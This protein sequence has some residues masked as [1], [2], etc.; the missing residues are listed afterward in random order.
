VIALVA[1]AA[2][3]LAAGTWLLW[4]VE[5][6]R[7]SAFTLAGAAKGSVVLVSVK[8]ASTGAAKIDV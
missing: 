3:G 1:F 5:S 7:T 4:R 8:E 6:P 2:S